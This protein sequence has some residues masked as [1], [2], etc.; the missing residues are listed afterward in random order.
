MPKH[1]TRNTFYWIIWPVILLMKSGQFMSYYKRKKIIKN[2]CKNCDLKTSCKP[3][4][5]CKELTQLIFTCSM[6][7][8]ETVEEGVKYVPS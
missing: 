1:K 2:V 8:I 6:S 3:F 7:T 4:C 5:V